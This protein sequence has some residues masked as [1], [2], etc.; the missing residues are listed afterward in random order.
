MKISDLAINP[1]VIEN[2]TWVKDIPGL[3]DIE[4]NVRGSDC[5][6]F[7]T[8]RA[9]EFAK[10]P[11]HKRVNGRIPPEIVA[12]ITDR[13]LAETVLR[14]WR[15]M[16]DDQDQPITF[17]KAQALA[18]LTDPQYRRFREGVIWAADHVSAESTSLTEEAV[19]K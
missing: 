17:T 14:G 3:G 2:G 4:L 10:V 1:A 13:C 19:G 5:V 15:K 7:T 8:M 11:Q 18:Y 16:L 9:N 6:A 12:E